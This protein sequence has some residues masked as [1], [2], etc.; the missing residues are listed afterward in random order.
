MFPHTATQR[1]QHEE[2]RVQ[3]SLLPIPETILSQ[4]TLSE[5]LLEE[6]SAKQIIWRRAG[7]Y[8]TQDSTLHICGYLYTRHLSCRRSGA[9]EACLH[10]VTLSINLTSD[11]GLATYRKPVRFHVASASVV[12]SFLNSQPRATVVW[13]G[14]GTELSQCESKH[15]P[16]TVCR[17]VG[18][19][20]VEW[21][22]KPICGPGE[23]KLKSWGLG[24]GR[25]LFGQEADL[26]LWG[27]Q[28]SAGRGQKGLSRLDWTWRDSP[29]LAQAWRW[30]GCIPTKPIQ[31]GALQEPCFSTAA[32]NHFDSGLES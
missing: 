7:R 21:E 16:G 5:Y 18:A 1:S 4:D 12:S 29:K 32:I 30:W 28:K 17:G 11:T 23:G 9:G 20:L 24:L 6:A 13:G 25:K 2:Q 10:V 8:A 19:L 3:K 15:V 14:V 27:N 22:E 31:A 26:I